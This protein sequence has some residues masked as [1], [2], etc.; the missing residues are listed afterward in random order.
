MRSMYRMR[1]IPWLNK[2]GLWIIILMVSI[3]FEEMRIW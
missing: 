1:S 2:L 3:V